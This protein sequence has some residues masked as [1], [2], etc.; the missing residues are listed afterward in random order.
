MALRLNARAE[1]LD[2]HDV[3]HGQL[4]IGNIYKRK[5]ALRPEAQWLWALNGVS[6]GPSDLSISGSAAELE[7]ALAGLAE[8]WQKWLEWAK[9]KET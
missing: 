9:L 5:A 6:G 8:Q 7:Q 4:L 2:E 1:S 3:F